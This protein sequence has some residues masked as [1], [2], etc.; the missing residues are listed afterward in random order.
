[1]SPE[2]VTPPDPA[3]RPG[4]EER[5]DDRDQH[6]P[7]RGTDRQRYRAANRRRS[8]GE[9]AVISVLSIVLVG[10]AT[11]LAY[12]FVEPAPPD[13]LR[14]ASGST[15]GAYHAFALELAAEFE[16]EGIAFQVIET[17]GSIENLAL[18]KAGK[19]DLAFVQSGLAVAAEH[20]TLRSL[21]SLYYE[22]LWIF[23]TRQPRPERITD[24]A[25]LRVAIG[26]EG[27]GT[28][29]V[30]LQLLEA[31]GIAPE[32]LTLM[33]FSD[34]EAADELLAGRIDAAFV[35]SSVD[36]AMVR[37]L[38]GSPGVTL[39]DFTRAE[40]YA[41]R[42]PFFNRLVLPAAVIDLQADIPSRDIDLVAAAAT[43]VSR[44]QVHPALI[45]LAMQA[46]D[47][48]FAR[49]TLFSGAERF[50]SADFVDLPLARAAERHFRYGPPFLQRYLPFWAANL[51]DRLKLLA[52]PL[53]ALL[54]PL[55][56]LLPPAYRWTVRKKVFRWYEEVQ[57]ID[58]RAS[59]DTRPA[60]LSA[61]LADL[62]RIEDDARD[63]VVPLGYAHELYALRQHIDLLTQQIERRPGVRPDRR[64]DASIRR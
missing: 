7:T 1:V 4:D 12:Q 60:A 53:I 6:R 9:R 47:R 33:P 19:V 18:L 42:Y 24:L 51:I 57:R 14:V 59:D 13:T 46:A 45:G 23:S 49:T 16:T 58:Q 43:L 25:G 36:G 56:R 62:A 17:E 40:A 26:P 27:S 38:L 29:R 8:I 32:A 41:R 54:L 44:E 31:N 34:T 64:T 30:A 11:W 52:L 61:C 35:I 22:P 2:P 21:A 10:G 39:M 15:Q 3:S 63:V 48:V 28:R 5:E 50:P 37:A 20:P 55:S